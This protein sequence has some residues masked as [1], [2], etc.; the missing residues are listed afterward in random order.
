MLVFGFGHNQAAIHPLLRIYLFFWW[1]LK[2]VI[3]AIMKFGQ[4]YTSHLNPKNFFNYIQSTYTTYVR[5]TRILRNSLKES[6][7]HEH[8]RNQFRFL[9]L[10]LIFSCLPFYLSLSCMDACL[11]VANTGITIKTLFSEKVWPF[12]FQNFRKYEIR[13]KTD[14]SSHS[15]SK[16]P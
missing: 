8:L 5:D 1:G 16:C 2:V 13:D 14:I 3:F 10:D 9:S 4:I 15:T 6:N 11:I 12:L 7:L